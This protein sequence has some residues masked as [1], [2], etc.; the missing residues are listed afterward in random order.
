MNDHETVLKV[1]A[2]DERLTLAEIQRRARLSIE[3]ARDA[4]IELQQAKRLAFQPNERE[5][6]NQTWSLV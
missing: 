6:W 5:R 3:R 1:F 4:V 2:P